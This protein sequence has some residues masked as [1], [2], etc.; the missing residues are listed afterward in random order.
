MLTKMTTPKYDC[1]KCPGYCCSY[2]VINVTK[3]D[4]ERIA[5][6]FGITLEQAE[7]RYL[8]SDHGYK[9]LLNR[10]DDEHFARI[11]QFFDT[12]QR[13]CSIYH[14]KTIHLPRISRQDLRLLGLPEI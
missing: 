5:K 13:N 10:K 8:H 9:R 1:T 7:K 6:H 14:R 11:C 12:D 3:R 2:P 4:A